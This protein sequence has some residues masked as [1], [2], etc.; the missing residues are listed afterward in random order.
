MAAR[1][2]WT[3]LLHTVSNLSERYFAVTAPFDD[4]RRDVSHI[5]HWPVAC[6]ETISRRALLPQITVALLLRMT[7]VD[8]RFC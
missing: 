1:V 7:F 2:S 5:A 6:D 8:S 3:E 4:G